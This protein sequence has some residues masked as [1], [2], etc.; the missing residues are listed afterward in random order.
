[1]HYR[2][3]RFPEGKTKAVTFS[4]DDGPRFDLKLVQAFDKYNIK[5]TFNLNSQCIHE[6]IDGYHLTK[7]DVNK[8]ILGGGHEV[9]VHGAYHKAPGKLRPIDGIREFLQ[10]RLELEEMFGRIIRGMA[11]PDSGITV[12][13]NGMKYET[14]KQYL[15]DLDIVYSRTLGGDN[16]AFML[17]NDWLAWMP[18]AHHDNPEIFDYIEKFLKL[19][20]NSAYCAD[21]YPRLFYVW[22][23]SFEFDRNNNWDRLDEI[24]SK[25]GG[26]NDIW[27]ATNI[28][29]YDY[30]TAYNSLIFSADGT[31]VYNPSLKTVW[32]E[33]DKKTFSIKS[34]ETL[35]LEN[36]D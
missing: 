1:M 34:G 31:R 14:I 35:K 33:I 9:A 21:H 11:Y 6:E 8:Y 36:I 32:F 22:G 13:Y 10:C 15:T 4:Y 7:D 30:V 26:H 20:V 23:H 2:F 17:P 12:M 27:Y 18:T 3:L 29:I 19:D 28:E 25:L 24:C 5:A 16:D